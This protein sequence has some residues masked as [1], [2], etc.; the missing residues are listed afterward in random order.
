MDNEERIIIVLPVWSQETSQF[1]RSWK[2]TNSI[3]LVPN[4]YG[5]SFSFLQKRKIYS[6]ILIIEIAPARWSNLLVQNLTTRPSVALLTYGD[7]NLF[8]ILMDNISGML[9]AFLVKM[10]FIEVKASLRFAKIRRDML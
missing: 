10:N 7:F 6:L 3:Q 9:Q 8:N 5:M 4:V 2:K 1:L